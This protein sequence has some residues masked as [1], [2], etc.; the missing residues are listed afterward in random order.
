MELTLVMV[1]ALG[2]VQMLR[3]CYVYQDQYP[4]LGECPF[5]SP[6]F[7][8]L[9]LL[10]LA[11]ILLDLIFAGLLSDTLQRRWVNKIRKLQLELEYGK[12]FG[13]S[14]ETRRTHIRLSDR[15]HMHRLALSRLESKFKKQDPT[16]MVSYSMVNQIPCGDVSEKAKNIHCETKDRELISVKNEINNWV[17]ERNRKLAKWN[18]KLKVLCAHSTDNECVDGDAKKA[19]DSGVNTNKLRRKKLVQLM[20]FLSANT[21]N[22]GITVCTFK[23]TISFTMR[24][25]FQL[26]ATI[27]LFIGIFGGKYIGEEL[28]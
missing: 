20:H 9:F 7:F 11:L 2:L 26:I 18:M 14:L 5:F 12:E 28:S 27:T 24:V 21:E 25:L 17:V 8:I 3:E 16:G 23:I 10:S 19:T 13:R 4:S 6:E 22:M 1:S 15:G